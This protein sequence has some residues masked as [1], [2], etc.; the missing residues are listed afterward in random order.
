MVRTVSSKARRIATHVRLPAHP[1]STRL[2]MVPSA[3]ASVGVTIP[4]YIEPSTTTIRIATGATSRRPSSL[5]ANEPRS[6]A[7]RGAASGQI[8]A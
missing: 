3:A 1:A 4:T 6:S 5:E 7:A 8:I 2:T